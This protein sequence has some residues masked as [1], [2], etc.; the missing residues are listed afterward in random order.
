[1]IEGSSPSRGRIRAYVRVFLCCVILC[2]QE[3]YSVSNFLPRTPAKCLRVFHYSEVNSQLEHAKPKL[4][5]KP[6]VGAQ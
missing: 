2:G 4:N 3:G 1:M 5:K 6:E